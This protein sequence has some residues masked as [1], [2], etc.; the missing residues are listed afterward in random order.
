MARTAATAANDAAAESDLG[1]NAGQD[2]RDRIDR[3]DGLLD[4]LA[5]V[6]EQIKALKTQMKEDGYNMRAVG[7]IL[8][9]RRRGAEFQAAQLTLELEVDTYRRATGLPV[10]LEAAQE[11]VRAE[12]G[13][14]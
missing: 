11:A 12:A 2:L 8:K 6:Q 7:Q 13:E 3:L 1:G 9:E 10:T 14:V 5:E 4:E